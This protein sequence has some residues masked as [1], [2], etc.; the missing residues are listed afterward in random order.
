ME[1]SM[2]PAKRRAIAIAG[3]GVLAFFLVLAWRFVELGTG[4]K[5]EPQQ[6]RVFTPPGEIP[7]FQLTDHHGQ[8][9]AKERL[10]G[11][12][13]LASIGFTFCPDV[14]PLTL[15]KIA[16]SF[17][18]LD[19]AG[20]STKR[21]EYVLFSVDPFRDSPQ[22]L[23]EYVTFYRPE[24]I[25]VTGSP[26]EISRVV[27]ALGLHYSYTGPDGRSIIKD[28]LHRPADPKYAVIH[29]T[30]LLLINPR[31]QVAAMITQPFEPAMLARLSA[32]L[33]K[34]E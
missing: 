24:F 16:E 18:L 22:V 14:C 11:H 19:Q 3:L 27:H 26:E 25:G 28:V 4:L 6:G 21:P 15:A 7:A 8:P 20:R 5:L 10:L 29:S 33:P 32:Q 17:E 34:D 1:R 13:T 12:W 23:A 2:T 9:F 30:Q 31:G